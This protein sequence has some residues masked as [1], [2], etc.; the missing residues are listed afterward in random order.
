MKIINLDDDN[1]F[2]IVTVVDDH[3]IV[4][5]FLSDIV[6]DGT[7]VMKTDENQKG[8]DNC[9]DDSISAAADNGFYI[10]DDKVHKNSA[11]LSLEIKD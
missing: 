3:V 5:L 10:D 8:I 9:D 2:E 7:G 11:S 1:Y 6:D 4:D